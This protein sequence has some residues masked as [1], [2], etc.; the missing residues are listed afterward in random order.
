MDVHASSTLASYCLI[1]FFNLDLGEITVA[2]GRNF[3]GRIG[4]WLYN[5]VQILLLFSFYL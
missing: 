4:L 1:Y 3:V 5:T 2:L